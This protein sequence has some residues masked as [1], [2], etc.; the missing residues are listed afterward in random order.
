MRSVEQRQRCD[1]CGTGQYH[2]HHLVSAAARVGRTCFILLLG[3][4]RFHHS[5]RRFV[6]SPYRGRRLAIRCDDSTRKAYVRP[7][8]MK[9]SECRPSDPDSLSDNQ[10]AFSLI[11]SVDP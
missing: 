10:V 2:R 7:S 4:G 1:G 8:S 5:I 11:A 6:V 9:R 3:E